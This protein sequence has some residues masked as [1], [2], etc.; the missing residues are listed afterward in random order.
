MNFR[1][2]KPCDQCPFVKGKSAT[3]KAIAEGISE[4]LLSDKSFICPSTDKGLGGNFRNKTIEHC[5]GATIMLERISKPNEAMRQAER[6]SLYRP[7]LLDMTLPIYDTF[8]EFILA[9][10]SPEDKK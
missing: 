4:A 10:H 6:K 2:T 8:S 5:I 9:Q 3:T 7:E 1:Q